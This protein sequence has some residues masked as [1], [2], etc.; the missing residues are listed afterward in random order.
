MKTLRFFQRQLH[1]ITETVLNRERFLLYSRIYQ[2]DSSLSNL[3]SETQVPLRLYENAASKV[4]PAS[5]ANKWIFNKKYLKLWERLAVE[6]NIEHTLKDRIGLFLRFLGTDLQLLLPESI[7][8]LCGGSHLDV[9]VSAMKIEAQEKPIPYENMF[10]AQ[11]K[12]RQLGRNFFDLNCSVSTV[13]IDNYY[14]ALSQYELEYTLDGIFNK[15]NLVKEFMVRHSL[16]EAVIPFRRKPKIRCRER[17]ST[18]HNSDTDLNTIGSF[19]TM[20]GILVT[21]Y[22]HTKVTERLWDKIYASPTGILKIAMENQ[23]RTQ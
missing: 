8:V 5:S 1:S 7:A 22:G 20:L 19:Y 17:R 9:W 14:L 3:K 2:L 15:D 11:E 13:F 4:Q 21:K 12:L 10:I 18:V 16:S 23:K 6:H